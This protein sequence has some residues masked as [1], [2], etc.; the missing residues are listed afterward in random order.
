VRVLILLIL[1]GVGIYVLIQVKQ[2]R[3]ETP[4]TPTPTPTRTAA[5]YVFEAED[6]YRA[7]DLKGAI[8]TYERAIELGFNSVD[9]EI[10]LTRLLT[11]EGHIIEAVHRAEEAVDA[12]PENARAWA[13]LGM[14]YDWHGEVEQAIAA[15]Q[16]ALELAPDY[17]EAHAYLAEAYA[18]D[19]DW[20]KATESAE[21]ALELDD[22]SVDVQRNYGYVMEVQGNYTRAIEAYEQG[23]AIHPNLAYLH[24]AVGKN[25]MA[26]GN[27]DA[28]LASFEKATQ[29]DPTSAEAYYRLGRAHYDA[30]EPDRAQEYLETATEADPRF[31]P[32][33][34]YLAFTYWSRRNYEDAIPQ[35]ERAIML[36]SWAARR[37]AREFIISLED[38]QGEPLTPS[39]DVVMRGDFAPVSLEHTDVIEA[40]LTPTDEEQAW[41][42]AA[43]SVTLDTRTGVYTLTL[44][45][46]LAAR[47][48]QAYVGWFDGVNTLSGEPLNTGYLSLDGTEL[49]V[50]FEA[51]WV[52]GPRI[53]Y[54]YT[55]GLAHF[56]LD[57]CDK[58]YP[59]FE[60]ALQI[61]PDDANALKGVQLCNQAESQ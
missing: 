26:L 18:D 21:K 22:Q 16:R 24:I 7:G 47:R 43:G 17:A 31:G 45:A 6:L 50:Q 28:A 52:A 46:M 14:A 5:S 38:R 61:D 19:G 48:G 25:Y 60:A 33:F 8:A 1:I 53:D 57:E 56:F 29:V 58:A 49:E 9:T 2:E 51:T 37:Q 40:S 54:F 11:L 41:Q 15:C 4:F 13:I 30:G 39:S 44:E 34:G 12:A 3:V 10:A 20:L 27:Y 59:L 36:E 23:L 42:G 55:L 32:A 35:L